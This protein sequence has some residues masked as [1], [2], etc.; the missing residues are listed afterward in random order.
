MARGEPRQVPLSEPEQTRR[1]RQAPA[2]L[3]MRWVFEL[4]LKMN[5][6]AGRLDQPFEIVRIARF[7]LEPKLLENVVRLVIPLFVP[8][9][10]K[11]TIK[12][13]VCDV[14]LVR[15]DTVTGQLGH[16]LRNP[17]AFVHGALNL[18]AAQIMSKPPT[19]QLSEAHPH[20]PPLPR[21]G[22]AILRRARP[23]HRK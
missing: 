5:E 11:R 14:C 16:K 20:P 23:C 17:L 7:G 2:V 15:I 21:E 6:S 18:L 9:T 10:K 3:R 8:A 12:R 19:H 13:M 22:E 1:R 4:L